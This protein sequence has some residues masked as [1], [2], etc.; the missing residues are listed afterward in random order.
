V[1]AVSKSKQQ[2]QFKKEI[3]LGA[4]KMGILLS[5]LNFNF[6]LGKEVFTIRFLTRDF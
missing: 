4:I 5:K 3:L 1:F 6:S 2:T